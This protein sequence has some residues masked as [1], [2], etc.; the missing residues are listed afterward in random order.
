MN[1]LPPGLLSDETQYWFNKEKEEEKVK[2]KLFE[3][4]DIRRYK[5]VLLDVDLP[6]LV[7][8]LKLKID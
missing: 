8:I 6:G 7:E 2:R 1:R 4:E 5:V 3:K